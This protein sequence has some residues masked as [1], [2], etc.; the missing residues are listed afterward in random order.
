[1]IRRL[2]VTPTIS[3]ALAYTAADA[4]GGKLEFALAGQY[5]GK[6]G[7]IVGL[8]IIDR[9]TQAAGLTLQLFDRDFTP[10]ADNAAYNPSD[11]DI[12]N[13]IGNIAVATSD[14]AGGSG[15]KVAT[16]GGLAVPFK[17]SD[18]GTGSLF[19]Q[20]FTQGTPTYAS[21]GDLTVVLYV[22]EEA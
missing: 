21:T 19:G 6:S 20:L 4:V 2:A 8:A 17:L 1:M 12:A 18:A 11:A 15:N 14:Y 16:K 9:S 7:V 3:A 22:R 5:N 13:A 10:T